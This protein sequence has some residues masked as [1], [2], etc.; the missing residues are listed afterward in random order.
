MV[1]IA[2]RFYCLCCCWLLQDC[3]GG[4]RGP[5]GPPPGPPG[6]WYNTLHFFSHSIPLCYISVF[7]DETRNKLYSRSVYVYIDVKLLI[8]ITNHDSRGW[9]RIW[10]QLISVGL[11]TTIIL[12]IAEKEALMWNFPNWL[13]ILAIVHNRPS[14]CNSWFFRWCCQ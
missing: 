12:W 13:A 14:L 9:Q 10:I 1:R 4:P 2:C 7:A 5:Y 11:V 3:F 6:F 8:V